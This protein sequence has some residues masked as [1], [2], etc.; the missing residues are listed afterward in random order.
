MSPNYKNLLI[1][2]LKSGARGR[3]MHGHGIWHQP[4]KT[5]QD[6]AQETHAEWQLPATAR[7]LGRLQAQ[8]RSDARFAQFVRFRKAFAITYPRVEGDTPLHTVVKMILQKHDRLTEFIPSFKE[9]SFEERLLFFK[10][11][12]ETIEAL[13]R[14]GYDF[15]AQNSQ[16]K[17]IFHELCADWSASAK[18][19]D[20]LYRKLLRL[21]FTTQTELAT[22]HREGKQEEL[23]QQ[24]DII[25][26]SNRLHEVLALKD[27]QYVSPLEMVCNDRKPCTHEEYWC[28]GSLLLGTTCTFKNR[29]IGFLRHDQAVEV[30]ETY[31]WVLGL[32]ED[33]KTDK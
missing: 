32:Y 11:E 10:T 25:E 26:M 22:H 9:M 8:E 21:I 15:G 3:H 13:L 28:V 24:Q 16:G 14:Q 20:I 23:D 27:N 19:R 5:V 7:V 30:H 31:K 1:I 2:L 12:F 18:Q 33:I 29:L 17:T 4:E 6:V